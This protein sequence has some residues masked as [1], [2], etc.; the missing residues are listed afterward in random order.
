LPSSQWSP[1]SSRNTP[2]LSPPEPSL[3]SLMLRLPKDSQS[4]K[5]RA[6]E[7]HQYRAVPAVPESARGARP[8]DCH[9]RSSRQP[10]MPILRWRLKGLRGPGPA[11][12]APCE[13]SSPNLQGSR[14]LSSYRETA[15]NLECYHLIPRGQ[16]SPTGSAGVGAAGNQCL[17]NRAFAIIIAPSPSHRKRAGPCH[18]AAQCLDNPQDLPYNRL[19]LFALDWL[20]LEAGRA[21]THRHAGSRTQPS[22]KPDTDNSQVFA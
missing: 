9:A 2:P 16:R 20:E 6:A 11:L 18:E 12:L 21:R 4:A 15:Y 8:S 1:S 13:L 10:S 19:C 3:I 14:Q 22:P 7:A 5:L 17:T